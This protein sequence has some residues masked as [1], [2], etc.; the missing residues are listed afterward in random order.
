MYIDI[1][2]HTYLHKQFIYG[3]SSIVTPVGSLPHQAFHRVPEHLGEKLVAKTRVNLQS[4]R[5][6][7]PFLVNMLAILNGTGMAGRGYPL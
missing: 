3:I 5:L 6:Q 1:N 7:K 4:K 2:I